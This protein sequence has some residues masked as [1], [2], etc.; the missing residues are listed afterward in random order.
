MKLVVPAVLLLALSGCVYQPVIT[1][2]AA[3]AKGKRACAEEDKEMPKAEWRARLEGDHWHV[4]QG[5]EGGNGPIIDVPR[6]GQPVTGYHDCKFI[7]ISD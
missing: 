1:E 3:I 4:W 6:D 2:T 7:I 5:N